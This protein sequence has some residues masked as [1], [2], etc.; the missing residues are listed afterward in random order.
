[1]K[2][3]SE[4]LVKVTNMNNKRMV[5]GI[6]SIVIL[7]SLISSNTEAS[8]L[9]NVGVNIGDV[10]EYKFDQ[11]QLFLR[12]NGT[13][14][15]NYQGADVVRKTINI[16]VDDF[17]ETTDQSFIGFNY[18]R[19]EF[20]QTERFDN[21]TKETNTFLDHWFEMYRYLELAFNSTTASFDPENYEFHPP[22]DEAIYDYNLLI[23]VPIFANTNITYYEGIEENGFP[24]VG[25]IYL[26]KNRDME[27]VSEELKYSREEYI[28]FQE[29]I[30][31]A[32]VTN[33]DTISGVTIAEE[34]WS[35]H[36]LT[37]YDLSVDV[38]K[39]LV[40]RFLYEYSCEM[41][42]GAQ[43]T[44]VTTIVS[45]EQ[46]VSESFTIDFN[47]TIPLL[48]LSSVLFVYVLRRRKV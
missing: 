20:N 32:N 45:F 5:R 6:V 48:I 23:G 37:R 16:T 44:E 40:K 28:T 38:E 24:E 7:I 4:L 12:H 25:D 8:L 27:D 46:L 47:L 1:M 21:I 22:S 29:N 30:F 14:Y 31:D 43:Y 19:I 18:D 17:Y 15:V 41:S 39:G 10:F 34:D 35:V 11:V 42:I 3:Y 36:S 33:E 13:T 26:L 9:S 2:V